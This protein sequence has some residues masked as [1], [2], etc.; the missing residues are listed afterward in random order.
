VVIA[1]ALGAALTYAVAMVLQHRGAQ[2]AA[3]ETSMR[4]GLFVEL[5]R[6]RAW[7]AGMAINVLAFGLRAVAL[8]GGS[9]VVV[10]PLVLS[11]LVFALVIETA[12]EGRRFTAREALSSV[13]VIGGVSVFLLAADPTR[14]H[15]AVDASRW[16]ALALVA[17]P[18]VVIATV[19]G[20]RAVGARKAAALAVGGG[21]LL[22]ATAALTK[23][24]AAGFAD[25]RFAVLGTWTPYALGVVG[26]TGTLMAQSAF[27]AAPLRASLPVLNVVEPVASI[28]IGALVFQEHL[29]DSNLARVAAGIGLATLVGGV[30]VL[31]RSVAD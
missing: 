30:I 9:L 18:L 19:A 1:A 12:T 25:D 29:T 7:L 4:P 5:L 28:V 6:R 20:I 8:G 16:L 23:Q 24:V 27:Q 22:A 15:T 26:L 13:A 10:Q 3:P 14:G 31:S 11:G 17:S 21:I 2:Q